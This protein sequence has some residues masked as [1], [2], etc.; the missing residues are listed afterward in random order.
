VLPGIVYIY[1][2]IF[3]SVVGRRRGEN[4]KRR[5]AGWRHAVEEVHFRR[6]AYRSSLSGGC[7]ARG[8]GRPLG[9]GGG[10]GGGARARVWDRAGRRPR[11]WYSVAK[12]SPNW[13]GRSLAY[14]P[15]RLVEPT[16]WPVF[17]PP[18]ARRAQLT[19]GQWSRP[20][21]LLMRGVRPNSPQ[22]IT[23]TSSSIPRT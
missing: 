8:F 2:V 21:P 19:C 14:S 15:R 18:P 1:S 17:M 13:T 12:I 9:A 23:V 16:A 11:L 10:V 4:E 7:L 22:A 5:D 6:I 20:A 3:S